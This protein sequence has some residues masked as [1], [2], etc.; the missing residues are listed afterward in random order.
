[1]ESGVKYEGADLRMAGVYLA[2]TMTKERQSQEEISRLL[3]IRKSRGRRGRK[4]TIFSKELSRPIPRTV[5]KDEINQ[6]HENVRIGAQ[7]E[8]EEIV[9]NEELDTK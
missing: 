5:I 8:E 9:T 2:T 1:M 4:P 6:G 7:Q 3:L